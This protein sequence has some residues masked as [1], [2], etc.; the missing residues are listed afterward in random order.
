VARSTVL[1]TGFESFGPH[2]INPSADV[3]KALDGRRFGRG[4]VRGVVLPVQ[5][6]RA[7]AALAPLL[8]ELDPLAVVH[9]GLAAGRAR[10]ALE[11]VALNIMDH[12]LPDADGH[13]AQDE[14]CVAGGPPACFSTLPLRAALDALTT[15]GVPAYISSTAGTYLCNF[16]LYRTLHALQE[17]E[18]PTPAGFVH[19]PLAASMVAATGADAPSMDVGLMLRAAEIVLAVVADRAS[20][21]DV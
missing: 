18:R 13:R 14:P 6:A 20:L 12:D 7:W 3:A 15:A 17:R 16:V 10:I 2:A 9:F 1:V 8:A 4:V 11:R 19:V 5:H 21:G